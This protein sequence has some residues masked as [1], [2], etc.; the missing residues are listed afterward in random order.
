MTRLG[1]IPKSERLTALEQ[2]LDPGTIRHYWRHSGLARDGVA[3][4]RLAL[5]LGSIAAWLCQRMGD[6][7]HVLATDLEMTFLKRLSYPNLALLRHDVVADDLPE[8]GPFDLVHARWVLEWIPD[9]RKSPRTHGL[10]A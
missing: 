10:G 7:G 5:A 9:R 4:R 2:G 1:N 3:G 8:G 6:D